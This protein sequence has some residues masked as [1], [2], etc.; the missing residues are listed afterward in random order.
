MIVVELSNDCTFAF[1]P[2]YCQGLETATDQQIAAVEVMG[3]GFGLGWDE[4]D[5]HLTVEGLL[6]GSFG[7]Q[8]YMERFRAMPERERSLMRR[9]VDQ[10]FGQAAE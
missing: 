6:M 3:V 9:P 2:R 1:P 4:L 5:T 8:R 10:D 7:S